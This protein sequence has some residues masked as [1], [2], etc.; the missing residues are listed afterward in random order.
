MSK[1]F[2]AKG[3]GAMSQPPPPKYASDVSKHWSIGVVAGVIHLFI[4]SYNYTAFP[5]A[6]WKHEK[7]WVAKIP[8]RWT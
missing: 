5:D 1:I 7:P 3:G 6:T 4:Y 2:L 8:S